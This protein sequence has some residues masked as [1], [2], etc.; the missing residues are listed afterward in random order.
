[1]N[2]FRG[3]KLSICSLQENLRNGDR[4]SPSLHKLRIFHD[5]SS[6]AKLRQNG[7]VLLKQMK[8]CRKLGEVKVTCMSDKVKKNC[9]LKYYENFEVHS[10]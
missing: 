4:P 5:F 1:M 7:L 10:K 8:F 6:T 2:T 9:K 3:T